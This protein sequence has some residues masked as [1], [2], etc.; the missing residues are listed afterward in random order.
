MENHKFKDACIKTGNKMHY[1][2]GKISNLLKG[3]KNMTQVLQQISKEQHKKLKEDRI[4]ARFNYLFSHNLKPL[5][6]E[7]REIHELFAKGMQ[8]KNKK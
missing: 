8:L 4:I 6:N 7:C 3:K 5:S 2:A 1:S